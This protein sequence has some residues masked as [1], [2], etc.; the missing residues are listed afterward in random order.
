M[1]IK[2]SSIENNI[3]IEKHG[4]HVSVNMGTHYAVVSCTKHQLSDFVKVIDD[5]SLKGWV[6][7]SGLTSEDGTVFQSMSKSPPTNNNV[8]RSKGVEL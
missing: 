2:D 4:K 7:T 5:L 3:K 1:V 8:N 6:I